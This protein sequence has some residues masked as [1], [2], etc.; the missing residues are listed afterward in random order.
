M[1]DLACGNWLL[2]A[3]IIGREYDRTLDYKTVG[4]ILQQYETL[5]T[6]SSN[7]ETA[8]H[9]LIRFRR[10]DEYTPIVSGRYRIIELLEAGWK[11]NTICKV[12]QLSRSLVY[13]WKRR[14]EEEGVIGL[15]NKPLYDYISKKSFR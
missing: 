12:M 1:M 2:S 9:L 8:E 3:A 11:V 5:F 10:Y 15:Y 4:S 14:F 13:F 7:K 6:F